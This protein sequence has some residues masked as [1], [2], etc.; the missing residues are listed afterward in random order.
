M[1]NSMLQENLLMHIQIRK[2]VQHFLKLEDHTNYIVAHF[3]ETSYA[4]SLKKDVSK[5]QYSRLLHYHIFGEIG[6]SL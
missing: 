5:R 6:E 3:L 1:Q 4:R 2:N